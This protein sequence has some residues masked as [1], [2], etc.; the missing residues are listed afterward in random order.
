[1]EFANE[2]KRVRGVDVG[3]PEKTWWDCVKDDMNSF[4]LTCRVLRIKTVIKVGRNR[5]ELSSWAP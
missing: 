4:G 5:P 2:E 1:M 3:M